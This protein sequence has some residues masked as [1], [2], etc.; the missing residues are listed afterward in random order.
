M[1][2]TQPFVYTLTPPL[3]R[4]DP[5]DEFLFN[6]RRGFCEHYAGSFAYLMRAAGVPARV[7]TG[8]QGGEVNPVGNYL[9]VRQSDAHAWVEVWLEG[10]GWVRIDPTAA[11]APQRIES[12]ISSLPAAEELPLLARRD[13]S[14]LRQLFLN[15][16]AVNNGWNQWV[17]GYNKQ[18]QME[19]FARL[20]GDQL[21]WQ[22]LAIALIVAVSGVILVIAF[23]LLRGQRAR[24]DPLQKLYMEFQRKLEGAGLKRHQHEGPRDFGQRAARRLPAKAEAIEEITNSYID[25][26]YR[27][28]LQPQALESFRQLIKAFKTS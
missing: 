5:M 23:F 21:S 11:V 10:R 22:D 6:T 12:G 7:V 16:D 24:I 4:Q 25:L 14:L 1:F 28:R 20:T 13:F 8:Y 19:L 17:L 27:S 26:R 18:R 9:I 3:L 2:R 15:W